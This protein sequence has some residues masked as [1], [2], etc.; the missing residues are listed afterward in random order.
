MSEQLV[1]ML[2]NLR[3]QDELYM[4]WS[5][6]GISHWIVV[7]R[8]TSK[9]RAVG[10]PKVG[11]WKSLNGFIFFGGGGGEDVCVAGDSHP[12]HTFIYRN[13]ICCYMETGYSDILKK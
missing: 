7:V 6:G 2:A 3:C 10:C 4:P 13:F 11:S 8:E 5:N 9:C 1:P 12:S